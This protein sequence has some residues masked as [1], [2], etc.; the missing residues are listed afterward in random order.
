MQ[1]QMPGRPGGRGRGGGRPGGGR[2][3][4]GHHGGGHP[5]GGHGGGHPP[6]G[7]PPHHPPGGPFHMHFGPPR[8]RRR[9]R[10]LRWLDYILFGVAGSSLAWSF[11]PWQIA[12]I[13]AYYGMQ[14]ELLT[15]AQMLGAM[16]ALNIQAAQL[17]AEQQARMQE[18]DDQDNDS[19][20]VQSAVAPVVA[21]PTS[22]SAPGTRKFCPSC[23]VAIGDASARFCE[24]C[25]HEFR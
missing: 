2:P 8:Y 16:R 18:M 21:A 3:G 13:E 23:G 10:R 17:N 22:T 11:T 15:E 4:G 14:A 1:R 12:Q 24:Q 19:T 20:Q 7:H 5:P 9:A 25:G 6:H